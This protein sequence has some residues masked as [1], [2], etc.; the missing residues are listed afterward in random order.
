MLHLLPAQLRKSE[1]GDEFRGMMKLAKVLAGKF[2]EF[3][4]DKMIR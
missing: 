2:T 3:S 4:S 1:V